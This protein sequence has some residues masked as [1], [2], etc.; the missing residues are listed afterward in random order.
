VSEHADRHL[1]LVGLG[2]LLAL[3]PSAQLNALAC[4]RYATEFGRGRVY[5]IGTSAEKAQ[6]SAA[7]VAGR[8][9]ARLFGAEVD[10][11]ALAGLVGKGAELR[12]TRL[13][14]SFSFDDYR[15]EYG[16]AV[17]PLF[18]L[19]P[20][21]RLRLFVERDGPAPEAG[22]TV[23]GLVPA[24]E[25]RERREDPAPSA[26]PDVAGPATVPAGEG[27]DAAG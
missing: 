25:S 24:K 16:D 17:V 8:P 27:G 11:A 20:E 12:R 18:A 19:N 23:F 10:Y 1:D 22:W 15:A 6:R 14:E 21:G 13:T 4:L 2:R 3:S 5:A 9:G 7:S 26:G